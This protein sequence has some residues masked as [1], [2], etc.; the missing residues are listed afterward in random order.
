[1]NVDA[2][3]VSL[4]APFFLVGVPVAF[5]IAFFRIKRNWFKFHLGTAVVLNLVTGVILGANLVRKS[6]TYVFAFT[7]YDGASP[8]NRCVRGKHYGFP[9]RVHLTIDSA[10]IP[11][12][13]VPCDIDQTYEKLPNGD[14][15][16]VDDFI[17]DVLCGFVNTV[18]AVTILLWIWLLCEW[19]IQ[20]RETPKDKTKS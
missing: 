10:S 11:L 13:A 14:Y 2:I 8:K 15:L 9:F 4:L 18:L 7:K 5:V 16:V 3:I 17:P 19:W 20:R 1:V 6:D 12:G